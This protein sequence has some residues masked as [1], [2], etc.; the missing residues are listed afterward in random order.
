VFV[1]D[2]FMVS[3]PDS[4]V[5]AETMS[6]WAFRETDY[7][8]IWEKKPLDT[9]I[10]LPELNTDHVVAGYV[11][12]TIVGRVMTCEDM[13]FSFKPGTGLWCKTMK[14]AQ[15]LQDAISGW[16]IEHKIFIGFNPSDYTDTVINMG[17]L[18]DMARIA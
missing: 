11:L 17:Q 2:G 14:P 10:Q 4:L 1:Y 15:I 8:V 6:E 18:V 5:D 12:K 7:R 3:G 16:S 13:S 9:I